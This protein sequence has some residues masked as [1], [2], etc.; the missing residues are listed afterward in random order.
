M[1]AA[2]I[3][4]F[5]GP[6]VLEIHARPTPLPKPNEVL[7]RVRATALNRA[8]LHQREGNYPA[9]PGA[10]ADIPGLEFAGEVAGVGS[11]VTRWREGDR[12]FGIVA[13]GANAEF[14]V[15]DADTVAP[16]PAAL[17]W[18]AAGAVPAAFITAYDA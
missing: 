6:E 14:L 7:V 11:S 5:G 2:I 17:S 16:V 1:K 8:D 12:V 13:G 9:P 4:K 18:T 15:T 3:T 10:P